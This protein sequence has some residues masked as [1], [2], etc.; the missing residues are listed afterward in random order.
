MEGPSLRL[1]EQHLQPFIGKRVLSVS[2]NST[3]D[4]ERMRRKVVRDIF[5]WGKHLV[6]QFDGFALKTHF[7]MFGTYEADVS[8]TTV[9]GDY[10]RARV[11]R[12]ALSFT[13]GELRLFSCSVK[14]LEE[15]NARANYDF[16]IDIMARAWDPSKAL[17]QLNG[18][19]T[20]QIADV[21]LDQTVFAGV[22]NIIKNEVLSL[23]RENPMTPVGS[24]SSA[25]RQAIIARTRKFSLQFLRWR[26]VFALR[27]N[28]LIYRQ[29]KCPHCGGPVQRGKTGVL[30]RGSYYCPNCQPLLKP[31]AKTTK[32]GTAA[33]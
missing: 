22:G 29:H 16:S 21:L 23:E 18:Q 25:Q 12:L 26:R 32:A 4:Q 3:L 27:K 10:K 6:I 30:Q 2:G 14:F 15:Q 5:A 24:L 7:L 20:A 31:R 28:L 17:L 19:K 1:A 8:G 13:N 11:P 33:R 9:T